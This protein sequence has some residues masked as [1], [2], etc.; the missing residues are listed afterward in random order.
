MDLIYAIHQSYL[1]K[2]SFAGDYSARIAV[3]EPYPNPQLNAI[4]IFASRLKDS[5][6]ARGRK[7][8]HETFIKKLL[9]YNM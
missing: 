6:P 9:K 3:L 5:K 4:G 8:D 7:A 1:A 2:R